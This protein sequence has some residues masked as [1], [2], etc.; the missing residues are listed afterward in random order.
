VRCCAIGGTDRIWKTGEA[1]LTISPQ[2]DV[3]IN[4][5]TKNTRFEFFNIVLPKL[6]V[7]ELCEKHPYILSPFMKAFSLEAP[8][9]FKNKN[10][11]VSKHFL[12]LVNNIEHCCDMGNYAD[13]Y[14]ETKVLDCL[15][16]I[17]NGIEGSE[18]DS[19]PVNL[20]LSEKMY[21]ARDIIQAQYK[22]PP[23]LNKLASMVGTNECTLKASF[24]HVFGITVFQYI[25]EYRM[26][27]AKQYLL[28]SCLPIAEI[29][30]L[31]GYDYPS[32][33]CTAF[34]R[35]YGMAPSSFRALHK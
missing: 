31:L 3:A 17:I 14:L 25:F 23:S 2:F 22:M 16:A 10:I 19:M 21:D 29:G 13:K 4:Q 7:K 28:D 20:V 15:S 12:H 34:R 1:N 6:L 30:I 35:K 5:F 33:F 32:H 27:L 8:I 26:N 9:Y 11:P 18:K 24:K